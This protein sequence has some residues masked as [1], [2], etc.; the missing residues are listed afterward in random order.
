MALL[1]MSVGMF[2]QTF[3]FPTFEWDPVGMALWPRILLV[4]LAA[5]SLWHI[6]RGTV[7]RDPVDP[8]AP[9][10]FILLAAFAVYVAALSVVGF[11]ASTLIVTFAY[12]FVLRG[13]RASDLVPS[14]VVAL[15]ATGAIFAIFEYTLGIYM[16]RGTWGF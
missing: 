6:L 4:L 2:A 5:L 10:A 12:S 1:V 13:G 7:E 3:T 16:P 11:Y 15:V 14:L 9:S 8:V